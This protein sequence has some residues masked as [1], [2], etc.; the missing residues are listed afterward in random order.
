M[1]VITVENYSNAGVHTIT[2]K[3]KELFWVK[4]IDV[5]KGLGV[6]NI[7][8]FIRQEMCG[9]FETKGLTKEQKNKYVKSE[10]EIS[11][12]PTDNFKFK[13]ATSDIL[14]KVIQ[15][16][17]GVKESHNSVNRME[18]RNQRENFRSLLEF[19]EN[20]TYQSKE[21]S[22]L[23]KIKKVFPNEMMNDQDQVNK[24]F[25]DLVFPVHKL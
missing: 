23:L 8:Q 9:I 15:N 16:C 11:R 14:E 17:R 18:K 5:Q 12:K 25:I 13:Y 24:Y 3:N 1:V 7:P 20:D 2:V 21:Y 4:M 19:K 22:T 10:G 6:K